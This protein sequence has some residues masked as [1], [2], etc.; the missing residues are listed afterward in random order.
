LKCVHISRRSLWLQYEQQMEGGKDG[1]KRSERRRS[2]GPEAAVTGHI[3]DAP[4]HLMF[5][6]LLA[7]IYMNELNPHSNSVK[8]TI[9]STKQIW[10]DI[11]LSNVTELHPS[12]L[13]PHFPHGWSYAFLLHIQPV[14]L[15]PLLN[16]TNNLSRPTPKHLNY[17]LTC[18]SRENIT[19]LTDKILNWSP[20]ISN[21]F[22]SKLPA[23][24]L[25]FP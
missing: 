5:Q 4:A 16:Q 1:A 23:I 12:P 22:L 13:C 3:T 2:C 19:I 6:A 11:R 25:H 21:N 9:I 15:Q 18:I 8:Q 14:K 24:L 17:N 10:L 7:A 20:Q